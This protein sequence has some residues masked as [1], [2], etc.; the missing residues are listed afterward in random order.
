MLLGD[1]LVQERLVM[2]DAVAEPAQ[3]GDEIVG[4]SPSSTSRIG[5]PD[6][7]HPQIVFAAG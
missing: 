5:V 6:V 4:G 1:G 2:T 3:G 7:G